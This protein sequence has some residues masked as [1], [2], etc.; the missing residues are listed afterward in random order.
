MRDLKSLIPKLKNMFLG[1]NAQAA[2]GTAT[3]L[4]TGIPISREL[5]RN[6]PTPMSVKNSVDQLDEAFDKRLDEIKPGA[7]HAYTVDENTPYGG[8]FLERLKDAFVNNRMYAASSVNKDPSSIS[9]N[10]NASRELYAHELGHILSQQTDLGRAVAALRANPKLAKVLGSAAVAGGAATIATLNDG[11]NE[12]DEAALIGLASTI[13]TLAD[14]ALATRQGLAIMD[15]ADLRANLGQRGRLASGLMSY[16]APSI[17]AA[18]IGTGVGN[19]VE[20]GYDQ[21][22]DSQ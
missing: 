19:A 12:Y 13:P 15:K 8:T 17:V 10:P 4:G 22:T 14:E 3:S 18:L 6:K 21:L 7:Q 11:N 16:A 20:Y 1:D 2:I 9:I 5:A